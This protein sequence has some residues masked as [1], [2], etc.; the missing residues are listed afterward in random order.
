MTVSDTAWPDSPLDA[1]DAAFAALTRDPDPMTLDLDKLGGGSGLPAGVMT[2]PALRD[3]LLTH[4]RAYTARDAVWRKLVLRARLDGPA[5]VV[6]AAGMAMPAL[7]RCAGQL[8]VGW[9]GEAH[10][11]D[12]EILT[13]FLAALRD[14][15]DLSKPAPY[16]SLCM[17]AWRAGYE[18]RQRLGEAVPVDDVERIVGPRTPTVPYGHPDLLVQRAVGLGLLDACDEQPYIDLRLGR[19]AIEPIAAAMGITVDALRMRARRI[20]QRIAHALA[21]G[22]L[23][24]VASPQAAAQLAATATHR[25]RTRAAR[26][27]AG[28]R[29]AAAATTV[30]A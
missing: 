20:D 2:L 24:G 18:L 30:A 10:D 26:A 11:I 8:R 29:T 28:A 21:S 1:V 7:R 13:G 14:R 3:W 9:S 27:T 12:A 15:T 25:K 16:A 6:A 4:P 17:A 19:R 23:T 22:L 5:W